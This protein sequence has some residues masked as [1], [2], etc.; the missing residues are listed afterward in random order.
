MPLH[1]RRL[2]W[3]GFNQAELIAQAVADVLYT[4]NESRIL[5]RTA[6]TDS[7]AELKDKKDRIKN[8]GNIFKVTDTEKIKNR[9]ILLVDD[10]CTTGA[11]LNQCA[12]VLK[13]AGAKKVIAFVVAR[14]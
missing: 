5:I 14:G 3:R 8:I 9:N 6:G 12:K 7:Q 10:I 13:E 1:P 2:N 4:Q 11:T